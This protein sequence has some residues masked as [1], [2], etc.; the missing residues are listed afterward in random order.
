M[1]NNPVLK[2]E[3][4]VEP[5]CVLCGTPYGAE[6]KVRAIPLDRVA[7]KY[8]EDRGRKDFDGARRHLDYWLEEARL[9]HD[10]R[11]QFSV[12]NEYMGFCRMRGDRE[13]A[14]A[15]AEAA[16]ALIERLGM[17][18][19]LSAA[20]CHLNAATVYNAFGEPQRALPLYE[21][22]RAIYESSLK[23]DDERLG[24]LY[25]NMAL[26]LNA[27]GRH[28]DAIRTFAKA[29]KIM[30]KAENGAPEEA[31]SWLNLANAYED[32]L[33][34]EAAESEIDECLDHAEAVLND[35]RLSRDA[36]Y[37][38]VCEKCAPTFS[39]YG[40]FLA[41]EELEERARDWYERA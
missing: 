22:A 25:N 40:R 36:N 41:A 12:H 6:P 26:A 17:A 28:E 19:S 13:G 31:V 2:P 37:A 33:G 20:T 39:Y 30:Q 38:F 4:Y 14:I 24:G 5:R 7:A 29:I 15:H 27:A 32:A 21:K 8:D 35:P 3:D 1:A 9:G 11:G 10:E 18:D 34:A 16:T 23:E